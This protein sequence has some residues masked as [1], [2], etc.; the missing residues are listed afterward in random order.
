M[1]RQLRLS[2]AYRLFQCIKDRG[3]TYATCIKPPSGVFYEVGEGNIQSRNI[4][5][6]PEEQDALVADYLNE[7]DILQDLV[8]NYKLDQIYEEMRAMQL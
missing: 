1:R 5:L 2:H 8:S 4:R 6:S 7:N 3:A